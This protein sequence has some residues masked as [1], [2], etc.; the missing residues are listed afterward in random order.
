MVPSEA[1]T[2]AGVSIAKKEPTVRKRD[3]R[4]SLRCRM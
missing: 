3:H 2:I 1:Q 4:G